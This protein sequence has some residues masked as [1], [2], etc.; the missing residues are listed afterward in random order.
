MLPHGNNKKK[1]Q[2]YPTL[3]CTTVAIKEQCLSGQT[4]PKSCLP[5]LPWWGCTVCSRC[6]WVALEWTTGVWFKAK[7]EVAVAGVTTPCDELAVV[8]QKA[9]L[10]D[11]QFS[12][13]VRILREPAIIVAVD[14][15]LD[16]VRFCMDENLFGILTVN[17][18]FN[19]GDFDVTITTYC[20]L[21]L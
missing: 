15:Q 14:R 6:L 21:L 19:L 8:M 5:F 18:T 4:G 7:E 13:E 11:Q 16:D 20:H 1:T 12:R 17:P 2:F 9:H 3:P 10:E